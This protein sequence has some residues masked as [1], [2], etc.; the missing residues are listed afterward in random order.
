MFDEQPTLELLFE[1]LGLD[2][3]QTSIDNF[4]ASHQLP[5]GVM[6]HQADFW[7]PSQCEFLSSHWQKDDEWSIVIDNLNELLNRNLK[8]EHIENLKK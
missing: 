7:S 4:V 1:Q 8:A 6:M 5:E 3:D 2:A